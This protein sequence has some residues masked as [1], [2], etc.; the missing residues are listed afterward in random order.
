MINI[1]PKKRPKISTY[2]NIR[3]P[4]HFIYRISNYLAFSI[5]RIVIG[6]ATTTTTNRMLNLLLVA[7]S[8]FA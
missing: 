5:D 1:Y 2:N 8:Q 3:K 7:K 6:T 4:Y